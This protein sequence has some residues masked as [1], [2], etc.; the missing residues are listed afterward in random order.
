MKTL[1]LV[2]I[3]KRKNVGV[4]KKMSYLTIVGQFPPVIT[5]HG[6]CKKKSEAVSPLI[7]NYRFHLYFVLYRKLKKETIYQTGTLFFTWLTSF[8]IHTISINSATAILLIPND[9]P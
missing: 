1:T 6:G 7:Q 4:D 2:K 3:N 5:I 9:I 8:I